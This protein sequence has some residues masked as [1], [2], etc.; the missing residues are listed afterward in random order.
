M[1][2]IQWIFSGIGTA[3]VV[4]LLTFL[5]RRKKNKIVL[6]KNIKQKGN[7]NI[8]IGDNNS[9]NDSFNKR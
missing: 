8:S 1:N 6:N 3:L 9:I 4:G 5:F 2:H 7:V